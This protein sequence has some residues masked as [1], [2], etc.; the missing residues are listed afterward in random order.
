[1]ARHRPHHQH[2]RGQHIGWSRLALLLRWLVIPMASCLAFAVHIPRDAAGGVSS[3]RR[4]V[5]GLS[6]STWALVGGAGSRTTGKPSSSLFL[7]PKA[8]AVGVKLQGRR[9]QGGSAVRMWSMGVGWR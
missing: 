9:G 8:R 6:S 4:V 5:G 1:M 7:L 3:S 2:Q